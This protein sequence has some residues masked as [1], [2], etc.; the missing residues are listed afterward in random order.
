MSTLIQKTFP[1]QS[2]QRYR[3]ERILFVSSRQSQNQIRPYLVSDPRFGFV[4][5]LAYPFPRSIS[6]SGMTRRQSA[7]RPW[8]VDSFSVQCIPLETSRVWFPEL[9]G[10]SIFYRIPTIGSRH[11]PGVPFK[12]VVVVLF[13]PTSFVAQEIQQSKQRKSQ[14]KVERTR[15][16]LPSLHHFKMIGNCS[17][18]I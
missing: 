9:Q 18:D 7:V 2:K 11:F 16:R 1:L 13:T 6:P 17:R 10:P 3:S 15:C 12:A 5:T 8:Y 14:T 4:E